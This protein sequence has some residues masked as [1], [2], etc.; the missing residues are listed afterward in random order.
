MDYQ[1]VDIKDHP[2]YKI[3]TNGDIWSFWKKGPSR[4]KRLEG[5]K[6]KITNDRGRFLVNLRGKNRH[7]SRLLALNFIDNPE[8]KPAA[9]HRDGKLYNN[10]V[11]NLYW[12]TNKE[13]EADKI[14]HGTKVEGVKCWNAKLDKNKVEIIQRLSSSGL[15]QRAIATKMEV[16]QF[17]IACV[18]TGKTWKH[19]L[20][21]HPQPSQA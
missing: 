2:G 17:A 11:E 6:M 15:S 9:C 19:L 5:K 4:E 18:L 20:S 1:I 12:G 8:N 16:S 7:I 10:S 21:N 3:D 13:N 14:L